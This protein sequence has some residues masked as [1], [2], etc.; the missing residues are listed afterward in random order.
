[1]SVAIVLAGVA[2]LPGLVVAVHMRG[3]DHLAHR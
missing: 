3:R 2:A 1:M